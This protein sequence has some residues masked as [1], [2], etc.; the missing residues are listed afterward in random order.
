MV[1]EMTS[2]PEFIKNRFW[3]NREW[4]KDLP[5]DTYIPEKPLHEVIDEA[6]QNYGER[7]AVDF[8]G[9]R[10]T[11]KQLKNFIDRF[12][13]L[14]ANLGIKKGDVVAIYSPNCPQFVVAYYGAMKAGA[15]VTALSP[16]YAPREVE[17]QLN[18]SGAKVLFTVE[19]LY[20]NFN[21]VRKNTKV[22]KVI[23]ANITG[24]EAKVDGEFIDF[25]VLFSTE[26]K[27]PKIDWDFRED[28]AVLQYTGGTTGLPKAAMLTHQ[29][30]VAN[31]FELKPYTDIITNWAFSRRVVREEGEY[32]ILDFDGKEYKTMKDYYINKRGSRIALLPWYHI[33]GQTVD[34]NAGLVNG[35]LL[36]IFARFEP[37]KIFETIEK[38]RVTTFMGAPAIFIAYVNNYP[39]LF[40]KYDISSLLYVNNGAGPIPAE[41]VYKWDELTSQK[42]LLCEGYGL[43]EASPVTH[44]HGLPP[45]LRKRKVGS[46]GPPIPNTYAAVIDPETLEFLPPGKEGELVISGPQVMKGYWNRPRETEEVFFYVDG[47]KWL[48]TG[49]IAK[50]DE[51]GYFYIVDRLKDI[52]KYKGHS[53]YPREVEEVIYEH[54]AVQEVCV[55]GLPDIAAGGET[56]KAYVVLRPEY[57]GKV[58]EKDIIDWCK[59]RMASYKYP[60]VVEFRE[61]LPKSAAGKYLRRLLRE[62]ELKKL[63][64]KK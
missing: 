46:I 7:V 48:R 33:Y 16:L 55:V 29:N 60:R 11:Y 22:E 3:L 52:I 8:Y 20:P 15:T 39:E 61:S 31:C 57:R 49:D 10:I 24:G 35:E 62:E 14:L 47:M 4:P 43:S 36:F 28:V 54:P 26:P 50:M 41:I 51:D 32:L 40:K 59:E 9:F 6:C 2:V 44:T 18:D 19:Q 30:V 23:V 21:A 58:R 27:P 1:V 37:E 64:L 63:G 5:A 13:T 34:L 38:Y 45:Q 56:I 42:V 53:V 25:R 12:A 17:Y